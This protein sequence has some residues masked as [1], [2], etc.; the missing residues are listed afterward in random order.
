MNRL[1]SFQAAV[2]QNEGSAQKID[3]G[4]DGKVDPNTCPL[5]LS[6]PRSQ[7]YPLKPS[8]PSMGCVTCS[9]GAP[10]QLISKGSRQETEASPFE[11]TPNVTQVQASHQ[12]LDHRFSIHQGKP[13][14]APIF[15]PI[16]FL[17]SNQ[18]LKP[19]TAQLPA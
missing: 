16:H 4:L 18:P 17:D 14:R 11:T 3:R 5:N 8:K 19:A 10:F 9:S 12:E 2:A 6:S 13:F 15:D 7:R 1:P